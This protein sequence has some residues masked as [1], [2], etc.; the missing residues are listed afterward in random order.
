MKTFVHQVCGLVTIIMLGSCGSSGRSSK[1]APSA[2]PEPTSQPSPVPEAKSSSADHSMNTGDSTAATP[3]STKTFTSDEL[4]VLVGSSDKDSSTGYA[5][6]SDILAQ[7]Y[8]NRHSEQMNDVSRLALRKYFC[9]MELSDF[10]D[11]VFN[12]LANAQSESRASSGGGSVGFDYLHAIG[13]DLSGYGNDSSSSSASMTREEARYRAVRWRHENCGDESLYTSQDFT[14]LV[15]SED[16]D[17]GVIAAWKACVTQSH[18]GFFC[19]SK[20]SGDAVMVSVEWLPNDLQKTVLPKMNIEWPTQHNLSLVSS[21]L[22]DSIGTGSGIAATFKRIDEKQ[23]S[24]IQVAGHDAKKQVNFICDLPI[25][26]VIKGSVRP[27]AQ[28]GI[29]RYNKAR[30]VA[31]GPESFNVGRGDI[32]GVELYTE[33]R[34]DACGVEQYK[35]L[36]SPA[37][38]AEKYRELESLD[39]PGARG[40]TR[41]TLEHAH[42]CHAGDKEISRIPRPSV[43]FGMPITYDLSCETP[44]IP[45]KCRLPQF[46]AETWKECRHSSHGVELFASCRH[47][48]HGVERYKECSNPNFGIAQYKECE[49]ATFGVAEYKSCFVED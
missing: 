7:G 38:G 42:F 44:A 10:E 27:D 41:Y 20:T 13:V 26:S 6:C 3:P 34:S 46:G 30:G 12:Y 45:T 31:C 9:S 29:K 1:P 32:C 37:C 40:T 43:P 49:S 47:P 39:C 14:H 15:V 2:S 17:Q 5:R 28:C 35:S 24:V 21:T 16:V 25:P 11:R 18:H 33:A 4:M 23:P 48:R 8:Y 22:P 19:N 36:R